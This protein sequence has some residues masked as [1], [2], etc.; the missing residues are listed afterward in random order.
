MSFDLFFFSE[1]DKGIERG[2]IL[3]YLKETPNIKIGESSDD[4]FQAIYENKDTGV[5]FLFEY[6]RPDSSDIDSKAPVQQGSADT[7]LSFILNYHRP[8]FFAM[9]AMPVVESLQNNLDLVIANP[10]DDSEDGEAKRRNGDDLLN[11]WESS[12]AVALKG[13]VS[14]PG[15]DTPLYMPREKADGLW[16][17]SK[18]INSLKEGFGESIFVPSI[19]TAVRKNEKEVYNFISWTDGIPQVFPSFDYCAIVVLKKKLFGSPKAVIKGFIDY[20]SLM[21]ALDGHLDVFESVPG[22]K[23]L[24]PKK[25]DA[26]QT[27]FKKLKTEDIE[28]EGI[29]RDGFVDVKI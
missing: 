8:S 29:A 26:V 15:A 27:I 17:Y 25:A 22:M 12:N 23:I 2:K 13:F 10:Q 19:M 5:Y 6:S 14:A 11:S 1:G 21:K 20:G 9:E 18:I 4:G 28:I 24:S 7:G 3:D 16:N